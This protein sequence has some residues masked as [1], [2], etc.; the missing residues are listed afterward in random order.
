MPRPHP[1]NKEGNAQPR[2]SRVKGGSGRLRLGLAEFNLE[3]DHRAQRCKIF[4]A[5]FSEVKRAY[6]EIEE[7][8]QSHGARNRKKQTRAR[9]H[10]T[11][12]RRC[13]RGLYV[14]LC[15]NQ[16]IGSFF[17]EA[18]ALRS[19][20]TDDCLLNSLLL[21]PDSSTYLLQIF[22]LIA[23]TVGRPGIYLHYLIQG[24]L[25]EQIRLS[26]SICTSSW[27]GCEGC[28]GCETLLNCTMEMIFFFF[29][30]SL[31]IQKQ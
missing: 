2:P 29:S 12:P 9:D 10:K 31:I 14:A 26:Q 6:N 28:E 18:P 5:T 17:F 4:L 25:L 21:L 15:D 13:Q 24:W 11:F 22:D 27:F 1:S 7:L 20:S 19:N 8:Q 16:S 23:T 3:D 30:L